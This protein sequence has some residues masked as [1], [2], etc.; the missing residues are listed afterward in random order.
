MKDSNDIPMMARLG[1]LDKVFKET[2]KNY[3]NKQGLNFTYSKVLMMLHRHEDGVIQ[4]DIVD[5]THLKKSTVSLTLKSMEQ[6][7]YITREVCEDD[8]RKIIVKITEKGKKLD[9]EIRKCFDI[10]E[11]Y[12]IADLSYEEIN[13]FTQII[14]KLKN[15]LE[16]QKGEKNV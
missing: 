7:E 15:S 12:I 10:I 6:E 4:N 16:K 8:N 9:K 14:T 13:T 1:N 3:C 2:V 5:N 11:S